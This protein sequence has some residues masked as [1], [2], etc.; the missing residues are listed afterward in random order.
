M[1]QASNDKCAQATRNNEIIKDDPV[2]ASIPLHKNTAILD[3]LE[4]RM[5]S[6]FVVKVHKDKLVLETSDAT[7]IDVL[8]YSKLIKNNEDEFFS[9]DVT[10]LLSKRS[11]MKKIARDRRLQYESEVNDLGDALN[12]IH[13]FSD[14]AVKERLNEGYACYSDIPV[15]FPRGTELVTMT[16]SGMLGG[17]IESCNEVSSMFGM[18]FSVVISVMLPTSQGTKIRN[19]TYKIPNF[20]NKV[21]ISKLPI[22]PIVEKEKVALT[23][24]GKKFRD[25]TREPIAA[26]Y[27]GNLTIPTWMRDYIICADGRVMVDSVN[28][29]QIDSD[30]YYEMMRQFN[31]DNDDNGTS[32]ETTVVS[33][34]NLWRCYPR[35]HGFS[36]RLKRWGWIDVEHLS[37]VKWRDDA[38][39]QLVLEP[40]TKQTVLQLV[41][42]YG[43]SFTDFIEGKSGGLVFLLH[44]PSGTGKAQPLDCMVQTPNG[45]VRMGDMKTGDFVLT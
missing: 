16:P 39:S 36:M 22:R 26:S 6:G 41:K 15:L 17:Q 1:R 32:E 23:E 12:S 43:N 29:A 20:D 45:P 40:K 3:Y 7:L 4:S 2:T 28:F 24:R 38:F 10:T 27:V 21:L 37:Q 18:F 44:G 5:F 9:V 19:A 31:I 8:F 30:F 34:D 35:V 33:D 42:H 25:F 14:P 13:A 11:M